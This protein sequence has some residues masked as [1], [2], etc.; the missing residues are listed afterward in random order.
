MLGS[1][2]EEFMDSDRY[3]VRE[4]TLKYQQFKIKIKFFTPW[5]VVT[6]NKK[7]VLKVEIC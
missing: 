4:K 2:L 1:S 7:A 6:K 5:E 3:E